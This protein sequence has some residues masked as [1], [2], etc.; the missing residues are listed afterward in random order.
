[1]VAKSVLLV[2][3][4]F[5]IAGSSPHGQGVSEYV[6]FRVDDR[7][8]IAHLVKR[9]VTPPQI[10]ADLSPRPLA[11][12]GYRYFDL[13]RSWGNA[14]TGIQTGDEW[15]VHT[16]PERI[17]RATV[18]RFVGGYVGCQ[19]AIGVMLHIAPDDVQ[20][21][22]AS[23]ARYFVATAP[24]SDGT[25]FTEAPTPVRSLGQAIAST[26]LR[27]S[28]ESELDAILARELPRVRT[29]TGP[30]LLRGL[31]DPY[32]SNRAWA[33]ERMKIEEATQRG[34]GRLRYNVQAFQLAKDGDA[35]FFVRADWLVGK[36]QGFAATLWARGSRQIEVLET[37][38]RPASWM[39]M[40]LFQAGV[41]PSHLGLILNVLDRDRD[42]WGE[43][44]FSQ[45]G[46]ESRTIRL[47]EVLSDRAAADRC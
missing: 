21:F 36:Q 34:E 30:W 5:M 6:A 24:M 18:E 29:E 16:S 39:R 17:V 32:R 41:T 44:L 42:G 38:V 7:R 22:A 20:T 2:I 23:R 11:K 8:V 43:V 13:P 19:E 27:R 3:A 14:P 37:N 47:L 31:D 15:L 45:E 35:V 12:F 26:E 33:R 28:L 9:E 40:S 25:T 4:V 10:D 46:Y 1:M